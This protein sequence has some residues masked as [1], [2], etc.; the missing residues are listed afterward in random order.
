[1]SSRS[2]RSAL[3][4]AAAATAAY[5]LLRARPPAGAT[6]WTRTNHRGET[7]TLLAGPAVAIGGVAGALAAGASRRDRLAAVLATA[8]AAAFGGYDDLAGDRRSTGFRGHL[9]A[10]RNGELTS[11]VVKLAGIGATGLAAALVADGESG[12]AGAADRVINA[13]LVAGSA[14]LVNLFD[15]RPGRAIKAT[16]L[17]GGLLVAAS[18]DA[19][20]VSAPV[21]AAA[22][23]LPEDLGERAMLGDAGAN[24]LGALLGMAA[25]TSLRRW[26]RLAVL[27]VIVG[28]T[29]ASEFVSFT[30]VIERTGPLRWL[31]MLGRRPAGQTRPEPAEEGPAEEEPAEPASGGAG[32]AGQQG[33]QA[34]GPMPLARV[35]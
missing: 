16:A 34:A 27:S 1:M 29:T 17:A 5:G 26:D 12:L 19:D 6:T 11:G 18:G 24:A 20:A 9:A 14:N 31:D 4:A 25:A 30:R 32:A 2:A 10:L 35:R 13:A 8:G 23:M 21:A 7:V 3:V 33:G 15:L 28:L 22:A